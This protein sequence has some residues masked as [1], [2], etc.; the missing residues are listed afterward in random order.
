VDDPLFDSWFIEGPK[1]AQPSRPRWRSRVAKAPRPPEHPPL[2]ATPPPA[3]ADEAPLDD[4][5]GLP[6]A[7][8]VLER[9]AGRLRE[10]RHGVQLDYDPLASSSIAR[11]RVQPWPGP[12]A[13]AHEPPSGTFEIGTV[14]GSRALVIRFGV[15][16]RPD[17]LTE[18]RV[19]VGRPVRLT[20][21]PLL[22]EFVQR[23]F[24]AAAPFDG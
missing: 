7:A 16:G 6:L 1:D 24:S 11:L 18:A 5:D 21:E 17:T 12:F 2:P 22:I 8:T 10:G 13:D 19:D 4:L 14:D 20:L 23:V 9:L 15:E 3:A